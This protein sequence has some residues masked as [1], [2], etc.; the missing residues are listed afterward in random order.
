VFK[1]ACLF[2]FHPEDFLCFLQPYGNLFQA[3][4]LAFETEG[5]ASGKAVV[6]NPQGRSVV[7]KEL[8]PIIEG[9]AT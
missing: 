6:K 3:V 8:A 9:T 2:L 5:M 7:A 4:A 1:G